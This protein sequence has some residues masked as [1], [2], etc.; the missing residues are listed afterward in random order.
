MTE[1]EKMKNGYIWGDDEENMELQAR[2][3]RLVQQFN[4]MPPEDMDG[5]RFFRKYLER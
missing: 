1:Q 5:L 3:K 2:A 4:A